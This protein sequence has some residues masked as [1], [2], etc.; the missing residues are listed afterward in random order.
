MTLDLSPLLSMII[1]IAP[2]L[3]VIYIIQNLKNVK[4]NYKGKLLILYIS[5][6]SFLILSLIFLV[7]II[8]N[9][10]YFYYVD[11]EAYTSCDLNSPNGFFSLFL[12]SINLENIISFKAIGTAVIINTFRDILLILIVIK[13]QI[14]RK[15]LLK[16]L[17]T[18]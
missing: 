3:L 8:F 1:L 14:L 17:K 13:N 4:D 2:M 6:K 7:P 18:L 5:L 9:R 10:G 16:I 12:C 15:R 11:L